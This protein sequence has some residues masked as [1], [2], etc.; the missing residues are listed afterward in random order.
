VNRR[1]IYF[2][3]WI[4]FLFF[5]I[6]P[7][8][9]AQYETAN[10]VF[11][12]FTINFIPENPAFNASIVNGNEGEY[13]S[14]S[15]DRGELL[16]YTDGSTV[17]N[18][19]GQILK[20]GQNITP[21]RTRSIIIPK[22]D[23]SDQF[24]IFSYNA[25]NV[26]G[27]NNNTLSV[28]V[29]ATV[30]LA[31]NNRQGEVIEKNNVLF[32]NM[33]GTF[34]ISGNC[35]RSV[36]WLVSEVDT[37]L[38]EG[39]DKIYIFQI[40]KNGISGPFVS[41]PL[42]FNRGSNFKL[43]PDAR[44]LL[45]TVTGSSGSATLVADFKPENLPN[46]PIEN[47]KWLPATGPGEFS[48]QSRY[49][50][51]VSGNTISQYDVTTEKV[52]QFFPKAEFIGIPQMAANGKIY[53][54]VADE[55]KLMVIHQPDQAGQSC[56]FSESGLRIPFEAFVLPVFASNLFYRGPFILDAG[57]DKVICDEEEVLLG[58]PVN[59]VS[60]FSWSPAEHL[61]DPGKLQP[62]FQHVKGN[63][64]INSFTYQL[65]ATY[66]GCTQSDFVVIKISP[67]PTSALINGN[68]S[69]CPGV[70][71]VPYWSDQ[72][73]QVTYLWNVNGGIINSTAM[74]D[75]IWIDWDSS[76]SAAS[77][78]LQIKDSIGCISDATFLNV[79]ISDQLQ[80]QLPL[81]LDSVCIN[82]PG[83]HKYS[84]VNT[85]GSSYTWEI[86]GGEI[87]K[88]DNNEVIVNWSEEIGAIWYSEK[89][90]TKE[91]ICTGDSDTLKVI[92][93]KD[94]AAL[95]LNYVT[96]DSIDEKRIHLQASAFYTD[97][98]K[99]AA[100]LYRKEGEDA[101]N[102]LESIS[103]SPAIKVSV[104]NL[105]TDDFIYQFQLEIVNQ[106][107]ERV[108]GNIHN[109][110]LLNA[111]G[112]EANS[113]IGLL[114]N[115]YLFGKDDT[116]SY[117]V[118][119]SMDGVHSLQQIAAVNSDTSAMINAQESFEFQMRVK[120]VS[121]D[122]LYTALSNEVVLR[123]EHML[124]IPNVITPNGDGINDTFEISN[125]RLYPGNR[126]V[127]LNRYGKSIY[128][129]MNYQGGWNAGDEPSGIY[130]F[131]L[132]IPEKQKEFKGWLQVIR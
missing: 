53:V 58:S 23:K 3:W 118:L 104:D 103:P 120:A 38:T 55:N 73:E 20:N 88:S 28:I 124:Y 80:P 52:V 17:W 109:T 101:W 113:T 37:N 13:A 98:I 126:L 79:L 59:S 24:Y 60:S 65:T 29:Y 63:S 39:S 14:Y 57:S 1:D 130:Y 36:F 84:V 49:I 92:L 132:H 66:E 43:S 30:D 106:C 123:F 94:P 114:W 81:G 35:D 27:N 50:Y 33:H 48:S 68:T 8:A 128:E 129:K 41:I 61:D 116:T 125:I 127:I 44:K 72:R 64:Q 34:T 102:R 122:G 107:D 5:G 76:S 56:G 100:V 25:F 26:P 21:Y 40:D 89:S 115:N 2:Q 77:V 15:T 22:P 74:A 110:I 112:D 121:S 75:T 96:I 45:F 83:Q 99:D 90:I 131:S 82:L 111:E 117:M 71:N 16:I 87:V 97:R 7:E 93:F 32:N 47:I 31:A 91:A 119:R 86:T 62:L 9:L 67:K 18:G 69:V 108:Y 95:Q 6:F 11:K 4:C 105:M 46:D 51:L 42:N 78:R 12:D 54:P 85:P 10:W 19:Q 70:M